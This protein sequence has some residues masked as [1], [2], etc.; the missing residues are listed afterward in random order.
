M[1]LTKFN[2]RQILLVCFLS[3]CAI[4]AN[5][6]THLVTNTNDSGTGSFRQAFLDA[7]LPQNQGQINYIEF[8]PVFFSTPRTITL[9]SFIVITNLPEIVVNGAGKNLLTITGGSDGATLHQLDGT[10]TLKNLAFRNFTRVISNGGNFF[11]DE[12]LFDGAFNGNA[13]LLVLNGAQNVDINRTEFINSPMTPN[14]AIDINNL[15]GTFNFRNSTIAN[16]QHGGVFIQFNPS[17]ATFNFINSTLANN[18]RTAIYAVPNNP[19]T[20]NIINSTI[21]RNRSLLIG[22]G[23]NNENVFATATVNLRNSVVADN[24]RST[25]EG[26][27]DIAGEINSQGNNLIRLAPAATITGNTA[28]NITGVS[29]MLAATLDFNGGT[30]RNYALLA[31]SPAID[32]GNNCVVTD[33]CFAAFQTDFLA[34]LLTDQRGVNRQIGSNVDIGAFEYI[35]PSAAEVSIGGRISNESGNAIAR[36]RVSLIKQ[37]GEIL[38]A[39]TNAFGY[40]KFEGIEV[41]QIYVLQATNR[42]L[43]FQNNPRVLQVMED[44]SEENFI[45]LESTSLNER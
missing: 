35:A 45:T 41:G 13:Y 43:Q 28:S 8:E 40:Y 7:A 16:N 44:L 32:A 39:M 23:I 4:S 29:P 2:L 3:C 37:N 6:A 26:M 11:M 21:A 17:G 34:P 38:S 19:I 10:F 12:V 25:D 22:V 18:N 5:A 1:I 30:T 42:K 15:S 36:V 31:G 20:I 24:I 33:T 14:Y 9:N 27:S